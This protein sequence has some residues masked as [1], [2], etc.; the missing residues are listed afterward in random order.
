MLYMYPT[1]ILGGIGLVATAYYYRRSI[2]NSVLRSTIWLMNQYVDIKY[3]CAPKIKQSIARQDER[4]PI[5]RNSAT[6]IVYTYRGK[7]YISPDTISPMVHELDQVYD[8]DEKI[9]QINLYHNG[10]LLRSLKLEED[11]AC[12]Y[13]V[14]DAL[15]GPLY[16]F[17]GKTPSIDDVKKHIMEP[18]PDCDKITVL[19][20][21]F[22]EFVITP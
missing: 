17:H 18:Y 9:T 20:A 10:M 21:N 8:S 2:I 6:H 3:M 12:L 22:K 19:T 7:S 1:T 5:V 4:C 15:A 16:D 13:D 11:N 14:L